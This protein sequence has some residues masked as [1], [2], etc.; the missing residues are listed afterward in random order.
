MQAQITAPGARSE[1][2]I[3]NEQNLHSESAKEGSTKK[4]KSK[5]PPDLEV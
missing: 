5:P 4:C 2:L 1:K 3:S